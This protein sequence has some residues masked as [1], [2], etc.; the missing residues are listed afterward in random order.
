MTAYQQISSNKRRSGL[1]VALFFGLVLVLAVLVSYL[2]D[3][4]PGG[5][6]MATLISV[7][8]ALFG[9]YGGDKVALLTSGAHGPIAKNDNPYLYRLVENVAITAGLPMPKVYVI[10]DSAPNAFATGRDPKH[11]SVAFTT[12][13]IELMANEELEGVIAHE[14]SH[15][16]NYDTR[17]M[18]VV[19]VCV[20]IVSLMANMFLRFGG[21]GGGRRRGQNQAGL[22]FALLGVVL[23]LLSPIIAKLIQL[24]VSRKREFL[25]DASGALLTRYPAGLANALTKL[26]QAATPLLRAN[27]ATAHLYIANPFGR[28]RHAWRNLFSTHPP[29]ADR[30]KALRAMA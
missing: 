4:G 1:L 12:G 25:A 27:S 16:K 28:E 10:S 8:M 9:Y 15:V 19:I 21:L 24:A 5:F 29:I 30:V 17:L 23:L 6:I 26:D 13:I 20:G 3:A 14:L 7:G 2:Y 11:A 18:T 22:L